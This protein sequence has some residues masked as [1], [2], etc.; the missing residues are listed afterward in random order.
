[1]IAVKVSLRFPDGSITPCGEILCE[2][3]DYII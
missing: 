2:E 3:P 1:M